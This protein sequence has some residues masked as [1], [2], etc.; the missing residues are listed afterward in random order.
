MTSVFSWQNSVSLCPAS[1]CFSKTKLACYSRY[2]LTSYQQDN[3][4]NPSSQAS[5][6][7]ELR[8]SRCTSWVQKSQRKRNQIANIR[9]IIEN[10]REFQKNIY[11]CFIDSA[12]AFDCVDHDKPC[13]ILRDR[14]TRLPYPS[15]EKPVCRSRN[16][17]WN[18]TWNNRLVQNWER[19]TSRLYT[20]IQLI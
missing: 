17:S 8:T 13:K 12:K 4:Q 11:F 6:V 15:P 10:A 19:N 1:F 7:H 3:A 20:A 5:T 9:W 16:N 2:H 14:N 18:R